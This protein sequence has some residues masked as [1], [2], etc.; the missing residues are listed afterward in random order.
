MARPN[1]GEAPWRIAHDSTVKLSA[2]APVLHAVPGFFVQGEDPVGAPDPPHYA[3]RLG[4]LPKKTWTE[5]DEVIGD[6]KEKKLV[7]FLRHG[8]A[9][10]NADKA[11]VGDEEW[12]N[13]LQFQAD[14]TDAALTS[15]GIQQAK[16]AGQMLKEEIEQRGLQLD[17]VVVS[18]LDRT[19]NTYEHAFADIPVDAPVISLEIARETLGVCTCDRRLAMAPKRAAHPRVDFR[20]VKDEHD[21]WWTRDHRE[22]D[23]EIEARAAELMRYLLEERPERRIAVISHSGFIRGSLRALGHRFYRPENGEFVPFPLKSM[24]F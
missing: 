10:H 8:E 13:H 2:R 20:L 21:E 12:T 24:G 15:K 17:L 16:D 22:S 3:A 19:L 23:Q 1:G 5:I 9:Q 4:L 7:I 18:P 6:G 14:Y 11:R